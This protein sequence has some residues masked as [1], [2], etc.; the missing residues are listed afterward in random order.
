MLTLPLLCFEQ[1]KYSL[2]FNFFRTDLTLRNL[3]GYL[4]IQSN[5][6]RESPMYVCMSKTH[7]Q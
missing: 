6:E 7:A 3:V 2:L 4:N 5:Q 1:K